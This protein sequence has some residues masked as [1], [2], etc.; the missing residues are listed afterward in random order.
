MSSKG[1][2]TRDRIL[3]TAFRLAARDG[4]EGLSLG[5][6]AGQLRMSKSGLFAHFRSKEE[7]QIDL[8]RTGA[9]R[10][11]EKVL[12]PAFRRPRGLPRLKQIFAGWMRW[13]NDPA[14]PGG[15]VMMAAAIE[16]DDRE[17]PVREALVALQKELLAALARSAEIAIEEGHL[18]RRL[19]VEQFAFEL[20]AILLGFNHAQRL[21]R[22]PQAEKRARGAFAR[23]LA[24][25]R[26]AD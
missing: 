24:S 20:Y 10:F 19:D 7:L 1:V 6:I 21:L 25:A 4:L 23:L 22:D 8:L 18:R 3:D 17:G 26:A 13:A 15:C 12:L 2:G 14:L 16:L 5:D 9:A 11:V